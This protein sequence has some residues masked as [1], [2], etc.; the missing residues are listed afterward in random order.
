MVR[1]TPLLIQEQ[2]SNKNT[3]IRS[4][5]HVTAEVRKKIDPDFVQPPHNWKPKPYSEM[6]DE[7]KAKQKQWSCQTILK[8][9]KRSPRFN[10]YKNKTIHETVYRL[11]KGKT[12]VCSQCKRTLGTVFFDLQRDKEHKKR[13]RRTY[14]IDCRKKMNAE[15][16]QR[17]KL[18]VAND[19]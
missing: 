12:K 14:C 16:Y 7:Q 13:Y 2:K 1:P 17:R 5:K 9:K 18:K 8:R 3:G 15:A 19:S 6:T 4:K 10:K 11:Y